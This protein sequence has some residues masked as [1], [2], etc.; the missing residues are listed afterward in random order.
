MFSESNI[1]KT[2]LQ[3]FQVT[4]SIRDDVAILPLPKTEN[5]DRSILIDR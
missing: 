1:I 5:V 3:H 4:G 2:L